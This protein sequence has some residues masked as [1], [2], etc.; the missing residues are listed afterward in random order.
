M[1]E[2]LTVWL[3][4]LGRNNQEEVRGTLTLDTGTLI[5][6]VDGGGVETLQLIEIKKV[7]RV[8][9][10]PILMLTHIQEGDVLR[11]AFYFSKPPPIPTRRGAAPVAVEERPPGFTGMLRRS[12]KR[13]DQRANAGYLTGSNVTK[14]DLVVEWTAALREAVR[15]A[16][17]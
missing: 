8:H 13:R 6:D 3:V 15:A 1:P 5:F 7:H 4:P 11:T 16:K 2:P 9:G 12:G 17:S 10:S 14:K